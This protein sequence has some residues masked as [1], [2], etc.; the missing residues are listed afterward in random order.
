L[1][2]LSSCSAPANQATPTTRSFIVAPS[3]CGRTSLILRILLK[4]WHSFNNISLLSPP[5][6]PSVD[7]APKDD[8]WLLLKRIARDKKITPY[9]QLDVDTLAGILQ[10]LTSEEGKS[11]VLIIDDFN[12]QGKKG[13]EVCNFLCNNLDNMRKRHLV[14]LYVAFGL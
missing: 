11:D 10:Q 1:P 14:V 4:F 9:Y 5:L 12:L 3:G 2:V 13:T 8:D 7:I 6:D